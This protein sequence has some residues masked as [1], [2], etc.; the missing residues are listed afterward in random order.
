MVARGGAQRNPWISVRSSSRSPGGATR[1]RVAPPGLRY[2]VAAFI[3]GVALRST[4]GYHRPP[5]RGFQFRRPRSA[6]HCE[7]SHPAVASVNAGGTRGGF[8]A[9][10]W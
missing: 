5:L 3:P 7:N 2:L 6:F 8:F 4:P 10:A 1:T 9:T